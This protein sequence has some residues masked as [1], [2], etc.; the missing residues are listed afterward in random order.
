MSKAQ[1]AS[2]PAP[3]TRRHSGGSWSSRSSTMICRPAT[4]K[5]LGS[6]DLVSRSCRRSTVDRIGTSAG[7][8]R[9]GAGSRS[10]AS[11]SRRCRSL[12]HGSSAS[13][14]R[15]S[16]SRRMRQASGVAP[17]DADSAGNEMVGMR[18]D[19]RL[20]DRFRMTAARSRHR[21]QP[22]TRRR[23]ASNARGC[24]SGVPRASTEP[25]SPRWV[26]RVA[27]FGPASL[28]S[29]PCGM[30]GMITVWAAWAAPLMDMAKRPVVE[31]ETGEVAELQGA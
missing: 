22:G 21:Q 24:R 25:S 23:N 3:R 2:R 28:M 11:R 26:T 30:P 17:D 16:A 29:R 19:R 7:R 31:A 10:R 8:R 6:Y 20:A 9:S 13:V 12:P 27:D 4:R 5:T 14:R 15:R 1:T 18:V